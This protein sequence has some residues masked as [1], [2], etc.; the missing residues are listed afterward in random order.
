V[1]KIE[2]RFQSPCVFYGEDEL[3]RILCQL[4]FSSLSLS[5]SQTHP[6]LC[7]LYTSL[8]GNKRFREVVKEAYK[9]FEKAKN[10]YERSIVTEFVV[11]KIKGEGGRF[12]KR[13]S[14]TGQWIELSW[15]KACDKTAHALRDYGHYKERKHAKANSKPREPKGPPVASMEEAKMPPKRILP[16]VGASPPN[17]PGAAKTI[18]H[19]LNEM[20]YGPAPTKNEGRASSV[21]SK[22]ES[23]PEGISVPSSLY[24]PKRHGRGEVLAALI[25]AGVPPFHASNVAASIGPAARTSPAD[26]YHA[27]HQG[28]SSL[29]EG[30]TDTE[31]TTSKL[32]LKTK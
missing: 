4:H 14:R 2:D 20:L 30:S 8:A 9:Q 21:Q 28:G 13:D 11:D 5:L 3:Q 29:S 1:W 7:F 24:D 19:A 22:K 10:P 12:V 18:Q 23:S 26:R 16:L 17:R 25:A 32:P 31:D 15:S 6:L 27:S